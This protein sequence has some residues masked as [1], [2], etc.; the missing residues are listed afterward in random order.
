MAK[1]FADVLSS[2]LNKQII[3]HETGSNVGN[4]CQIEEIGA[5]YIGVRFRTGARAFYNIQ[6]VIS[7]QVVEEAGSA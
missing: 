4:R 3:L 1:L 2:Y 6:N 5:D 7:V